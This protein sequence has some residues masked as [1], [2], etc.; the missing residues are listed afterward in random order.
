[1]MQIYLSSLDYLTHD[2]LLVIHEMKQNK[3][4]EVFDI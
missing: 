4:N 1:M 2:N 3:S